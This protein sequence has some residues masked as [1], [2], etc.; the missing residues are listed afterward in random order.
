MDGIEQLPSLV[1][2]YLFSNCIN[3]LFLT[4][5]I[6]SPCLRVCLCSQVLTVL[7]ELSSTAELQWRDGVKVQSQEEALMHLLVLA[8]KS[9]YRLEKGQAQNM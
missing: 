4:P 6:I 2:L 7:S 8:E 9:A 5:L 1:T 3:I